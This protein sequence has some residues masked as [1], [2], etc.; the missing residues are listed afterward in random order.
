MN[1]EE[2]ASTSDDAAEET[3]LTRMGEDSDARVRRA[4]AIGVRDG[5]RRSASMLETR[6]QVATNEGVAP[7]AVQMIRH[8]ALDCEDAARAYAP[9]NKPDKPEALGGVSAGAHQTSSVGAA[10]P[11]ALP[12]PP[13]PSDGGYIDIVF[14]GPP[15]HESGRFIEVEIHD[16][17]GITL[18]KW[19]HRPDGFWALR[20]T[21]SEAAVKVLA[22]PRPS[23]GAGAVQFCPQCG[24][25]KAI[26]EDG[27]CPSCGAVTC[28]IEFARGRADAALPDREEL[29]EK[30]EAAIK[31]Y[32]DGKQLPW[33]CGHMPAVRISIQASEVVSSLRAAP[34][35]ELR[36]QLDAAK[37]Y[38]QSADEE[39]AQLRTEAEERGAEV[40]R[41]QAELGAEKVR[42]WNIC[43]ATLNELPRLVDTTD[44]VAR[45][46]AAA[47]RIK[48]LESAAPPSDAE[49]LVL[50]EIERLRTESERLAEMRRVCA[51]VW[52]RFNIKAREN[53]IENA[54]DLVALYEFIKD[55]IDVTAEEAELHRMNRPSGSPSDAEV[56]G[57]CV[58]ALK[59]VDGAFQR[60]P[61][62]APTV[63]W[64]TL[65]SVVRAALIRLAEAERRAAPAGESPRAL[66]RKKRKARKK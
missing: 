21:P 62:P 3:E 6:A 59:A 7:R 57:P 24:P 28:S 61:W 63:E 23:L 20:F 19:I 10:S 44:L 52:G 64:K 54:H 22:A 26:D 45:A 16:G 12:P 43:M 15:S 34:A 2:R 13:A 30:A 11:P 42:S 65:E 55:E 53:T 36:S 18:G 38:I 66:P 39:M 31:A 4:H 41:L 35:P 58:E 37:A 47:Q 14:D 60:L 49:P 56:L 8:A 1:L 29:V 51:R 17:R 5:L 32:E 46:K 33:T 48:E 9:E 40:E 27:C 50:A 25:I